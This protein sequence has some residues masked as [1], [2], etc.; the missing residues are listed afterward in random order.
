MI[1]F[2]LTNIVLKNTI[3]HTQRGT[4]LKGVDV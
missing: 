2:L 3:K 1:K 4:E